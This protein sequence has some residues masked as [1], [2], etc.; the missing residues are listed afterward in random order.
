MLPYRQGGSYELF[1]KI[2]EVFTFPYCAIF[3]IQKSG[4]LTVVF[5]LRTVRNRTGWVEIAQCRNGFGDN[6]ALALADLSIA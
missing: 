6:A 5:H 2:G 1:H 3:L 4:S